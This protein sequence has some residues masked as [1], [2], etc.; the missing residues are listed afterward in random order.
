MFKQV[1]ISSVF[2]PTLFVMAFLFN[3]QALLAQNTPQSPFKDTLDNKFDFSE[4]ILSQTGFLPIIG[5]ITE[6][7]LGFGGGG[8]GLFFNPFSKKRKTE[9]RNTLGTGNPPDIAVVFGFGTSNK[10]W[11]TGLAY[12]G[13]WFN[14]RLRYT[15]LFGYVSV[16]MDYYG[17]ENIQ[18]STPLTF[19]YKGIPIVQGLD[20]RFFNRFFA[21]AKYIYFSSKI[22]L[23]NDKLPDFIKDIELTPVN[24]VFVPNLFYD[25]RDNVLTPKKG[26]YVRVLD[27]INRQSY[28][29]SFDYDNIEVHALS[30]IP[31]SRNY[32]MGLRGDYR[33]STENAP[34]YARPFIDLR[35]IPTMRYQGNQTLVFET[36]HSWYFNRRWA[37]VAFLGAGTAFDEFKNISNYQG[38]VTGGVGFRYLGARILGMYMGLDIAVGPEQMAV[39][40]VFGSAWSRY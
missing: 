20:V 6:P 1:T 36:E 27:Y 21:G 37:G 40:I 2:I 7:A 3:S 17:N 16:N 34:F 25:S 22:S 30:F 31:L 38:Y 11:G 10:T 23:K 13:Y 18:L 32:I 9:L 4:F 24:S 5:L 26:M 12:K 19:N 29:S 35:G 39:Y 28:G 15:G 8:G 14:D 33:I